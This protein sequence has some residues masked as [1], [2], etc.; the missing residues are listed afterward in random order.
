[1]KYKFNT[2]TSIQQINLNKQN[3]YN[4]IKEIRTKKKN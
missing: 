3:L 2:L 4:L 1:M